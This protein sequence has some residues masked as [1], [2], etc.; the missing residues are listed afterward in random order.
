MCKE[1]KHKALHDL[2]SEP[3]VTGAVVLK[4]FILIFRGGQFWIF[5]GIQD[6]NTGPFGKFLQGSN[7]AADK[8]M[9][10]DQNNDG[11]FV[12]NETLTLF[13]RNDIFGVKMP[14][15]PPVCNSFIK[16][17]QLIKILY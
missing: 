11:V 8:W 4:D 10:F 2:C 16:Y 1:S 15:P 14:A 7:Y 6:T 13:M 17:K 12:I 3:D 9:G 5:S